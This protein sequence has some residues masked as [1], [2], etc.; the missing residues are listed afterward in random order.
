MDSFTICALTRIFPA[1]LLQKPGIMM[2]TSLDSHF[3]LGS[4]APYSPAS[5]YSSALSHQT[6]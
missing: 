6:S 1:D 2:N 5:K 3:D 4:R